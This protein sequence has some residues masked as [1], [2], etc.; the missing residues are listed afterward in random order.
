MNQQQLD[1]QQLRQFKEKLEQ[2]P[3]YREAP[4]PIKGI[5]ERYLEQEIVPKLARMT[6]LNNLVKRSLL[7]L[8]AATGLDQNEAKTVVYWSTATNGLKDLGCSP[9]LVFH[10]LPETG[11]STAEKVIAQVT[12]GE[13]IS[14]TSP[15]ALR[16]LLAQ[17][18]VV[19]IEEG[20]KVNEELILKRY[21]KESGKLEINRPI[22][23]GRYKLEPGNIYGATVLHKR[24]GFEDLALQ[25]RAITIETRKVEK[26]FYEVE[27][28]DKDKAGLKE[29]WEDAW[30]RFEGYE[31]SGRTGKNWRP[32]IIVAL[33]LGDMDWIRY[34]NKMQELT[35]EDLSVDGEFELEQ[36]VA[37]TID[38]FRNEPNSGFVYLEA[39]IGH[40]KQHYQVEV[41][42]KRLAKVA[43]QLGYKVLHHKLGFAVNFRVTEKVT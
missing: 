12:D 23:Y 17:H 41:T 13:F 39:M 27:L 32:L 25:S 42:N 22:G 8:D 43:R 11:K 6:Y 7:A 2:I 10:G 21:A 15:A 14:T 18:P 1:E 38:Y 26:A 19:L 4:Q 40:M 16:D 35:K 34:A 5:T 3:E 29:L 30:R 37:Y 33:A 9:P 36:I 24:H 20:D 28:T 31:A